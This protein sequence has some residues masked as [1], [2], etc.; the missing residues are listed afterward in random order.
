MIATTR[1]RV[2]AG[3]RA[4]AKKASSATT[5]TTVRMAMPERTPGAL[6]STNSSAVKTKPS[7]VIPSKTRSTRI[8]VS[9]AAMLAP[10]WRLS[11]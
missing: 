6:N 7:I 1:R 11:R 9:V 4:R 8:V 2:N 5:N 10:V 3:R